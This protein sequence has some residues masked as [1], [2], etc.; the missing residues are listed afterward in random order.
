VP[1][2][3]EVQTGK[4]FLNVS[5]SLQNLWSLIGP[6]GPKG[7]GERSGVS[8]A[9][10]KISKIFYFEKTTAYGFLNFGLMH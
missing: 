2:Q 5:S 6:R 9:V 3:P 10:P 4:W 7:A 1:R 8:S